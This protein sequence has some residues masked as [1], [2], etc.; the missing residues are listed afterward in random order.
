MTEAQKKASAKYAKE[1]TVSF[2][3]KLNYS[4]D[5]DIISFLQSLKNKQGFIKQLIN[6]YLNTITR[7]EI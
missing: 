6:E 3:L 7:R 4:T 1:N 2:S 5:A